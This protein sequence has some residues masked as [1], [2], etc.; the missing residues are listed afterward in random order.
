[1]CGAY[2]FHVLPC[3]FVPS[4]AAGSQAE[5]SVRS[6]A[7]GFAVSYAAGAVPAPRFI[8]QPQ[9]RIELSGVRG[10]FNGNLRPGL[11]PKANLAPASAGA[12]VFVTA[13]RTKKRPSLGE[14][15]L[16]D[17][18]APRSQRNRQILKGDCGHC[19]SRLGLFGVVREKRRPQRTRSRC[20]RRQR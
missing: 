15:A 7:D 8:I 2:P 16:V 13:Q 18:G 4:S 5:P 20:R 12:F 3:F 9:K 11:F 1:M 17:L 19:D 10:G 14:T 6:L